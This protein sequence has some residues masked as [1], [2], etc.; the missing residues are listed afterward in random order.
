[1]AL[2]GAAA[3]ALAGCGGSGRLSHA[4][5]AKRADAVCSAYQAKV[6][7]LTRPTSYDAIV[8]YADATLPLYVAA[9][10]KLSA[11]KPPRSDEAEVA[12][13]LAANRKVEQAVRSLRAAAMRHDLS[14]TNDASDTLQAASNAARRAASALGLETCASP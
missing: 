3:L 7:L 8:Q 6:Q 5:F 10:D 1:V 4:E 12:T 14:G 2:T 9:L 13:W 11:L